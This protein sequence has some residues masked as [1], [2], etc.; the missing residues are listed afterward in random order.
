MP[1]SFS[2]FCAKVWIGQSDHCN[3]E[4]HKMPR[5]SK[6]ATLLKKNTKQKCKV[7]LRRHRNDLELDEEDELNQP[8]DKKHSQ[9]FA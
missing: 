3:F 7:K 1:E 6:I 8:N 2:D 5:I 9:L 4:H